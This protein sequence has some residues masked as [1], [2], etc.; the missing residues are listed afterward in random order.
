[1]K[2]QFTELFCSKNCNY[3]VIKNS[4]NP[5]I[6]SADSLNSFHKSL[7]DMQPLFFYGKMLI[8]RRQR[9]TAAV[10][11][12]YWGVMKRFNGNRIKVNIHYV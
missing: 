9:I 8:E 4:L 2:L 7:A 12:S 10:R 3:K 11:T 1:M 5:C 6:E